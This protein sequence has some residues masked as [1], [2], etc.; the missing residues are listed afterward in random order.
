MCYIMALKAQPYS[1]I[2][3]SHMLVEDQRI[4]SGLGD[5]MERCGSRICARLADRRGA[6]LLAQA[7]FFVNTSTLL[8]RQS[9]LCAA[10]P[11]WGSVVAQALLTVFSCTPQAVG[12][13]MHHYFLQGHCIVLA[14]L[15]DFEVLCKKGRSTAMPASLG[16]SDNFLTQQSLTAYFAVF[17]TQVFKSRDL[18]VISFQQIQTEVTAASWSQV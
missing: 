10:L 13:C 6:A 8:P 9:F 5:T 12:G 7:H 17:K 14:W 16:L 2:G 4:C 15:A 3:G 18:E 11:Q 1:A